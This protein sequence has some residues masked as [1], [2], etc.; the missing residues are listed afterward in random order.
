M[1]KRDGWD[2]RSAR[3]HLSAAQDAG[4]P[5]DRDGSGRVDEVWVCQFGYATHLATGLRWVLI[6]AS[7]YEAANAARDD[8]SG[9]VTT[10]SLPAASPPAAMPSAGSSTR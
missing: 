1:A 7:Q 2:R 8:T 6:A 9:K 3:R 10:T 5:S 4:P